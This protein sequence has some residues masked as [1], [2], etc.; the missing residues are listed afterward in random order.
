MEWVKGALSFHTHAHGGVGGVMDM[1]KVWTKGL[2][3][4][5]WGKVRRRVPRET[6]YWR[7]YGRE[8]RNGKGLTWRDRM[9]EATFSS[10]A[11]FKEIEG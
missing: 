6:V 9:L 7:N 4:K 11:W 5:R 10:N 3:G 8:L 2:D 1:D